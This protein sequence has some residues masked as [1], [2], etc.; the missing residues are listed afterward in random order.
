MSD[1][2]SSPTPPDAP[3]PGVTELGEHR[4][5]EPAPKLSR[6]KEIIGPPDCPIMERWTVLK[7]RGR[8]FMIHHFLPNADDRSA[9]DHPS[10]FWT[11]VL[12]G[13][14]DD[15]KLCPDCEGR[16][17]NWPGS[18][19]PGTC[20]ECGGHAVVLNERMRPGML[21]HRAAEHTHRTKVGPRGC[22]TVV[23]M[24]RKQRAW[25]FWHLG[26]W[27]YWR[28]FERKYGF[29]MRCDTDA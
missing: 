26:E 29:G 9:H 4:V 28:D 11:L 8:K 15:M 17:L 24:Q 13:Y 12:R 23:L 16:G 20:W 1:S 3:S 19:N 18:A 10:P 5:G 7:F 2:P 27:W 6:W 14:Y 22:W 25:G 21:R